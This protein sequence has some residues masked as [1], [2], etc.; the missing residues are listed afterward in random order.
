MTSTSISLRSLSSTA[1]WCQRWGPEQKEV[2][3]SILLHALESSYHRDSESIAPPREPWTS[4]RGYCKPKTEIRSI[5]FR[6]VHL[7][8]LPRWWSSKRVH[9]WLL[10]VSALSPL[11]LILWQAA[12]KPSPTS[13]TNWTVYPSGTWRRTRR[14]SCTISIGSRQE[15]RQLID[16]FIDEP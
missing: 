5:S 11:W 1:F 2:L 10:L 13:S 4:I 16:A 15:H 9:S 14:S 12:R 7:E 6:S 3:F 8:F